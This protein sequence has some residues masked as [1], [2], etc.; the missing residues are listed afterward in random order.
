MQW[1]VSGVCDQPCGWTREG[2]LFVAGMARNE[3]GTATCRYGDAVGILPAHFPRG[4]L[5]RNCSVLRFPIPRSSLARVLL[6]VAIAAGFTDRATAQEDS[7]TVIAGPRYGAGDARRLLLG[8][9]YRRLWLTPIRVPLLRP[10]TFAGGLTVLQK[11]ESLE[12]L[13]L[14]FRG[15]DGRQYVFRSVDKEQAAGLPADL[16]NTLISGA[17]QDLVATKHPGAAVVVAPLLDAAGV[18]NATPRLAVMADHPLLGEHR[19]VFAGMLGMLEERPEDADE[20]R[21]F[22]PYRRIIGSERLLERLE[23]SAEDRADSRA[24]LTARLMDVLVGDWDRHPDQYRWALDE[25]GGRRLWVPIPRDRDNAFSYID[26]I[27]GTASVVLVPTTMRYEE[28]YQNLYGLL[29][30]AQALDRPIL[31]ELPP[32]VWDSVAGELRRRV[33]DAVIASA[34]AQLPAEWQPFEAEPLARKLRARRD[35]LPTVARRLYSMM[36]REVDVFGT[37]QVDRAEVERRADGSVHVRLLTEPKGA[38]YFDRLLLPAETREVRIHLRGGAD[39]AAVRGTGGSIHVRVLGGGGD[40]VLEDFSDTGAG[41]ITAFYDDRDDNRFTTRPDTRVD[42]RGYEAPKPAFSAESNP[43]PPRDWGTRNNRFFPDVRWSTEIG[44]E[45]GGGPRWTRYGFRRSPYA[46]HKRLTALVAPVTGRIGLEANARFLRTGGGGETRLA[47]RATQLAVTNFFGFGNE[48]SEI[49]DARVRRVFATVY[50]FAADFVRDAGPQ[51]QVTLGPRFQIQRPDPKAGSPAIG[52]P[53]SES[54]GIIGLHATASFDRRDSQVYPR[55]GILLRT[56]AAGYPAVWGDAPEGFATG[57]VT[58]FV[59]FP[60]P[61][62]LEPTIALR[63]GAHGVLGDP[64]FQYA[65]FLG[66]GSSLRG[67]RSN[68]FAGDAAVHGSAELRTKLGR[69]NLM[70]ARGDIGAFALGDVGRVFL[71]GES[72]TRWHSALGGGL[73]FGP[74]DRS[75]VVHLLYAYGETHRVAAGLGMPF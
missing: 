1:R 42:R 4:V 65:A 27:V 32:A 31:A 69:A 24:Y 52:L 66:G 61:G 63:A 35:A 43:P 74:L 38:V 22:G 25:R 15:K 39:H 8:S 57:G 53:G 20:A 23:E 13:S 2:I 55:A 12:T 62:G 46:T 33:T 50:D 60:L 41:A 21:G 51:L 48:T 58:G 70:L 75:V 45:I 36:A 37:D 14:R 30:N 11:G 10:D 26:G 73:W 72:S 28:E 68:R 3:S 67:H 34:V 29:H 5:L 17:V 40:D 49:T 18:L 71:S 59:Y 56:Y 16:Q 19:P 47:A 6:P 7:V 64:P 54:F 44:P 9:G